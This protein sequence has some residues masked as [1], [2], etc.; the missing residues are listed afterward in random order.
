[1][2]EDVGTPRPFLILALVT[3]ICGL[4]ALL[5]SWRVMPPTMT[6]ELILLM[7]AAAL[8]ENFAMALPAYSVSLS[9]PLAMGAIVLGGP[10]AAGL[11]AMVSSTNYQEIR[12]RRPLSVLAFNLGQLLII[13]S[14]G[15]WTYLALGGQ[16]MW[17]IDGG[18]QP[19]GLDAFPSVLVP[20]TVAA[21]VC[22]LVNLVF[23]AL[24]VSLMRRRSLHSMVEALAPFLPT[25]VAMGYVGYLLAQVCATS[26]L[27][28]PLFVVP[29]VVARQM[30][31]RYSELKSVYADTVRSLVGAL[32]A[33][34]PY[35][36]GHSERV[37]SYAGQIGRGLG[38]DTRACER[39][40]YAALLHD[41]GKLAL[42]QD[43]LTKPMALSTIEQDKMREHPLTGAAMVGRIRP[44]S[45][46]A[47]FVQAHHER[48]DGSG[49]PSGMTG[50]DI[51][52]AARIL[53]VADSYDAMT[54]TRAYR[55]AMEPEAALGE[56][57]SGGGSQFDP[58]VVDVFLN[59][60]DAS[61]ATSDQAA[62]RNRVVGVDGIGVQQP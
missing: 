21:I 14:L 10:A 18:L 54:T 59:L 7:L 55:C 39:L 20:M 45:E 49:Y 9:Y 6:T 30:Y 61:Q 17:T 19:L 48:F 15:G 5:A 2:S 50:E 16:V 51:P 62:L 11:V 38:L 28:L 58:R 12:D 52:L 24:G 41:L 34:D 42:P 4:A 36:R 8:S 13:T 27:A 33:K 43:L 56:L 53:A 1:M 23:T 32:E 35:T 22:A 37:A 57:E 25:Q 26:I 44:L 46:L 31:T 40:E 29:L 60:V 47:L 3:I